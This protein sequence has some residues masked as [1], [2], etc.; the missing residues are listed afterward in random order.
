MRFSAALLTLTASVPP[1]HAS[2][3]QPPSIGGRD[4]GLSGNAVAAPSDAPSIL[5]HNAAGVVGQPGTVVSAGL[6]GA[7]LTGRYRHAVIGYDQKSSE[8]PFAPV[9]WVSSDRLAPWYV[10]AGLYGTVG[11]SFNFAA[12]PSAG[13]PE[14]FLAELGL[15]QAGFVIGRE[16]VPGLR[17]GVQAAPAWG[18]I[19]MRAPSPLGAV[20]FDIDGFGISGATGLLYDLSQ[21]I[22]LGLSYRSPGVVYLRGD[23]AVADE[24]EDVSINLHTP[25]S[26]GVGIA[27][28][29]TRRLLVTAQAIW[30]DY[31]NF[32]N[33]VFRFER[34][35]LLNRQ[36]ISDARHTVRYGIG[37]EYEITEW[38]RMQT[39]FTREGWMMEASSLSPLLYDTTDTGFGVGLGIVHDRWTIYV[40]T[41]IA[42]M[43]DRLVSTADQLLFPGRYELESS[44][45]VSVAVAYRFPTAAAQSVAPSVRQPLP[46]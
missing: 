33:G 31:P 42:L 21:Q 11:S 37:L 43:E 13:I 45:G 3:L 22:T 30:T 15:I 19:R 24:D 5:S 6:I 16:I 39:G 1:A 40:N 2:M 17:L 8:T 28:R 38:L 26:A 12:Q 14:R 35:P 18:R 10:G 41:G 4:T 20:H 34:Y 32:E 46:R 9:L 7:T 27:H 23:G 25:Q 29:P 36:F 44:P